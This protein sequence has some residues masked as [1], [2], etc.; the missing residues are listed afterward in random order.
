MIINHQIEERITEQLKRSVL[1]F[2]SVIEER[3]QRLD[4]I[5]KEIE[6][7]GI[8]SMLAVLGLTSK[9]QAY[10]ETIQNRYQLSFVLFLDENGNI[11]KRRS[12]FLTY[13]DYFDHPYIERARKGYTTT[14]F[15]LLKTDNLKF[16]S[17]INPELANPPKKQILVL[18]S[19]ALLRES[20]N[21]RIGIIVAGDII[22]TDYAI[23]QKTGNI[24][25][26]EWI[27]LLNDQIIADSLPHPQHPKHR[28][29]EDGGGRMTISDIQYYYNPMVLSDYFN[30]RIVEARILISNAPYVKLKRK[31]YSN[32]AILLIAGALIFVFIA[33]F[34]ADRLI[35]PI[36]TLGK[37]TYRIAEGNLNET[38]PNR[39][40][41]E[42]G[43]LTEDFNRM[44]IRLAQKKEA[45]EIA[46]QR[47][48]ETAR[49]AGM[50][51]IAESVLHNIGNA[52]NSINT[53]IHKVEELTDAREIESLNKFYRLMESENII[54]EKKNKLLRFLSTITDLMGKKTEN[55]KMNVGCIRKQ[56]EQIMETIRLQQK[57][58][59]YTEFNSWID[60]NELVNDSIE[61]VKDSSP[62]AP[63]AWVFEFEK[64]PKL[65]LDRKRMFRIL[66][67]VI[68]NALNS[69]ENTPSNNENII[70]IETCNHIENG[71][72]Y[73]R[74][75]VTDTGAGYDPEV[76][77]RIF[78]SDYSTHPKQIG[79]GLHD[80]ANYIISEGGRIHLKSKGIGLGACLTIELP[81]HCRFADNELSGRKDRTG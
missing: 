68:K 6:E 32:A 65:Y 67:D 64:L 50:A 15:T 38:I 37:F 54:P 19:T 28:F 14:G 4:I 61:M 29:Y 3:T 56:L 8:Y 78:R 21:R 66:I 79:L 5:G 77:F 34:F 47:L 23:F 13:T 11:P 22:D 53:R 31:L 39:R 16:I 49:Q 10:T 36:K 55:L 44:V 75:I 46:N 60:I 80:S 71:Q 63:V 73:V 17:A 74:I 59:Q 62:Q 35:K 43:Q 57:Y 33:I 25:D 42:I 24:T 18:M 70:R 81:V 26:S 1:L 69:V 12:T 51:E 7:S 40:N 30:N 48:V 76:Q 72:D 41:D 2:S 9:V 45:L 27:L 20:S 52:V 58:T